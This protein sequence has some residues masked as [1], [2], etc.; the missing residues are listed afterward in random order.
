VSVINAGTI[1]TYRPMR[2]RGLPSPVPPACQPWFHALFSSVA[3]RPAPH[4]RS[5]QEI[6]APRHRPWAEAQLPSPRVEVVPPAV[7]A[8][9]DQTSPDI[10]A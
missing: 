5:R 4:P 10:I 6:E 1:G 7:S 9:A 8:A 2:V 3:L